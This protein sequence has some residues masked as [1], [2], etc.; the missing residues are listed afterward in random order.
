MAAWNCVCVR[1]CVR[2]HITGQVPGS[3]SRLDAQV[4]QTDLAGL[5]L[6]LFPILLIFNLLQQ[7]SKKQIQFWAP[8]DAKT[9]P[10][11]PKSES[12]DLHHCTK[13]HWLWH[14]GS[15]ADPARACTGVW[16]FRSRLCSSATGKKKDTLRPAYRVRLADE[17][18]VCVAYVADEPSVLLGQQDVRGVGH[19]AVL[20]LVNVLPV[21]FLIIKKE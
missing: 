3:F 13:Q 19:R 8:K 5:G 18:G 14:C 9:A 2:S 12:V 11:N 1:A 6:V 17:S 21:V 16:S 20:D 7:I 15:G 4:I 10:V